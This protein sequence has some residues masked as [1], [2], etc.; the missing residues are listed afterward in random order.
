[1]YILDRDIDYVHFVSGNYF[2][3]YSG[4]VRTTEGKRWRLIRRDC[5]QGYAAACM[6]E[7]PGGA[8]DNITFKLVQI[9]AI[10][11]VHLI[12]THTQFSLLDRIG[13]G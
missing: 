5:L 8:I 12:I 7:K 6:Y 13:E 4:F 1:M 3:R 10:I 11:C 2:D 9:T